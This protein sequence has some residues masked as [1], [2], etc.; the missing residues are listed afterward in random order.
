MRSLGSFAKEDPNDTTTH[1]IDRR[2]PPVLLPR[3]RWPLLGF[4]RHGSHGSR[5]ASHL[6]ECLRRSSAISEKVNHHDSEPSTWT[7]RSRPGARTGSVDS[8]YRPDADRLRQSAGGYIRPWTDVRAVHRIGQRTDSAFYG[9]AARARFLVRPASIERRLPGDVGQRL[10]PAA[11]FARLRAAGVP[12]FAQ[13]P[14]AGA[15]S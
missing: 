9:P 14:C 6:A 10:R 7:P 8:F 2:I 12:D 4:S 15:A 5:A 3:P 13:R 11:E 1:C